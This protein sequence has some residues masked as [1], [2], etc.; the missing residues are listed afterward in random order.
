M[1]NE[2]MG[3]GIVDL[4]ICSLLM[5]QQQINTSTNQHINL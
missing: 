5:R 3:F 4:L 1:V 2:S